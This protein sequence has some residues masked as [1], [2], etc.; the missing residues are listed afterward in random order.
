METE[1]YNI[2]VKDHFKVTGNISNNQVK[3]SKIDCY[4]T[5]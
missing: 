5:C 4:F 3:R 1:N 2:N